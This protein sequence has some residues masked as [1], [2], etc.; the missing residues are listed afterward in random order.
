MSMVALVRYE[1]ARSALAH[2]SRVDEAKAIRDKAEALR[3]Y[4]QQAKDHE[5]ETWAAEI[6]LRAIR[7]V[8][9]LSRE[10]EKGHGPGRGKKNS[11]NG[12]SFKGKALHAAGLTPQAAHRCEQIAA[13]PEEEFEAYI[14]AK[15]EA[16]KPAHSTELLKVVP[17][18]VKREEKRAEREELE[19]AYERGEVSGSELV[20]VIA[21][22]FR[23]VEIGGEPFDAIITDPPYPE[24]FVPLYGDLGEFAF[25]TLK[26]GGSLF[27]MCGQSYLPRILTLL[28][29]RGLQYNWTLAYLTPG[30]QA[31]QCWNRKVNTFWKPVIWLTK[32]K[33]AGDWLGDVCKSNVNDNDKEHHQWGQSVSGMTDLVER[34][35]RIGFH[36]CD[37]FLGGGTTGFVCARRSRKFTGIELDA[38]VAEQARKRILYSLND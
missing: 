10:L 1:E 26:P 34:S 6:K 27:V 21:G 33:Y 22:D 25:R 13:I 17:K 19:R 15:K 31:V 28:C 3:A 12:K 18:K 38:K 35:T 4:G 32:G 9:E 7:K 14:E 20:T 2:C 11:S 5:L 16:A 8:G 30:G 24:E 37:P 23:E 29:E 36:V